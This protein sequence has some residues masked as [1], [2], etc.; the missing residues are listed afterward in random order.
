MIG[1]SVHFR[2]PVRSLWY[3][4]LST[5]RDL[6]VPQSI[7]TSLNTQFN[8]QRPT[9]GQQALLPASFTGRDLIF[10]DYTGTGKS[11]ALCTLIA[12]N[13]EIASN[14][15]RDS[16][17]KQTEANRPVSLIVSPTREL[18]VQL[19][20]WIVS[21]LKPHHNPS[22]IDKD[23]QCLLNGLDRNEQAARLQSHVPNIIV[24]TPLRLRE[25]MEDNAIDFSRLEVLVLDEVDYLIREA[26]PKASVHERFRN[27][28][29]PRPGE[30][31]VEEIVKL[32]RG[33]TEGQQHPPTLNK[34][35]RG[36]QGGRYR[37]DAFNK[38]S[39]SNAVSSHPDRKKLQII[40]TSATFPA[41]LRDSLV[42]KRK[43]LDNPLLLDMTSS[44]VLSPATITHHVLVVR[45]DGTVNDI[46]ENARDTLPPDPITE[47]ALG[48]ADELVLE[49]VARMIKRDEIESAM[50][51]V[52]SSVALGPIIENFKQEGI[53]VEKLIEQVKWSAFGTEVK[54]SDRTGDTDYFQSDTNTQGTREGNQPIIPF[55]AFKS[56]KVRVLLATEHA[57]RGLDLPNTSHV[58]ILGPPSSPE[59]YLHMAG[60]VGR[61]GRSG[62]V[63]NVLSGRRHVNNVSKLLNSLN[64]KTAVYAK[65][66]APS[67]QT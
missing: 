16:D 36:H 51:F 5:F 32:R 30:M 50:V 13:Y 20:E 19:Y 11:I 38:L 18:A 59:S 56:G 54:H 66:M 44:D 24:G 48:D 62:V 60:R 14:K 67:I 2:K 29:H 25:L 17:G 9:E 37:D 52:A 12:S 26:P 21:L 43:W 1:K 47:M 27:A 49:A 28:I 61:F 45:E 33:A 35:S 63:V 65:P 42:K 55:E 23:I 6:G 58:F 40:T 39:I 34:G 46:Y 53:A 31:L 41:Y 3:R 57:A 7:T 22:T 8:I 10:R 4:F 15:K 64:L